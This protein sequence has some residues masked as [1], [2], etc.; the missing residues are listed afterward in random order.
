M[1]RDNELETLRE[2]FD[3]SH[4]ATL[5]GMKLVGLARGYARVSLR[6]DD[7]FQNWDRVIHGGLVSSLVDQAFGCALNTLERRYVAVQLSVN[8]MAAPKVNDTIISEGR[9][10]H[11]GMSLGVAQMVVKDSQDRI[12]AT[13]TGTALGME[14]GGIA[15]DDS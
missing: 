15:E 6:I 14:R 5:L 7:R 3:K 8:F 11:S 2:S 13:A 9:V 4:Y 1:S 12:I 10:I